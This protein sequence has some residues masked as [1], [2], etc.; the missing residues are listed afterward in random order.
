MKAVSL[1]QV[2]YSFFLGLMLTALVAIG[3]NT[4]HPQPRSPE[5]PVKGDDP[6][7]Q[8]QYEEVLRQVQVARDA[9]ALNQSIILLVCATA[10]L[11]VSLWRPARMAVISNGLLLGGVFT[12]LYAVGVSLNYGEGQVSRFVVVLVATAVTVGAGY[13][14]FI[15]R[16]PATDA[17]PAEGD[18]AA[19][20]SA[21]LDGRVAALERRLAA[22]ARALGD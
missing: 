4:F 8:A 21:E 18:A 7:A 3:L 11:A 20:G 13:L 5:Y 19:S 2:L 1:L 15:R 17:L 9:W 22:L 14:T 10:I 6:V 12:M 16:T